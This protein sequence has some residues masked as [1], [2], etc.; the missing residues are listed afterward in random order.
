MAMGL[1]FFAKATLRGTNPNANPNGY[2]AEEQVSRVRLLGHFFKPRCHWLFA[3]T[4]C[5]DASWTHRNHATIRINDPR[6]T[7]R[8]RHDLA[9]IRDRRRT[10][11]LAKAIAL[12]DGY[13]ALDNLH[14][15]SGR[16]TNKSYE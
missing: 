14:G 16:R 10:R 6:H 15:G 9:A 4:N 3:H 7:P 12:T 5:R 1:A 8:R 11:H 13:D 2:P